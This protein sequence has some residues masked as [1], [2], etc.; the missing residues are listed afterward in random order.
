MSSKPP[1]G[2]EPRGT[3]PLGLGPH[4]SPCAS[5]PPS[6]RRAG[7]LFAPAFKALRDLR[8]ELGKGRIPPVATRAPDESARLAAFHVLNELGHLLDQ[9]RLRIQGGEQCH[10]VVKEHVHEP[11]RV[12]IEIAIEV[13]P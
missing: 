2:A 9:F 3:L 1:I 5:A 4:P 7:L 12:V 11:G 10:L 8:Q 6:S 13:R